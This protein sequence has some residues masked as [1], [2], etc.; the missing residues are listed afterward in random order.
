MEMLV[1]REQADMKNSGA[2]EIA[3][4]QETL[5]PKSIERKK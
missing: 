3:S 1:E 5:A 4:R 2:Q